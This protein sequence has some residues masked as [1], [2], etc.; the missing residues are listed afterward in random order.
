MKLS[1]LVEYRNYI[2]NLDLKKIKE[3]SSKSTNEILNRINEQYA[4]LDNQV[5]KLDSI[6]QS[7]FANV[8]K[9]NQN[10]SDI[11]S[12]LDKQIL[13]LAD[14]YDQQ[15]RELFEAMRNDSSDW[16]LQ[17]KK[18]LSNQDTDFFVKRSTLYS[19]WT[20]PTL[21]FRPAHTPF[22]SSIVDGFPT[23]YVDRDLDLI[24]PAVNQFP[25]E[26]ANRVRSYTVDEYNT[27]KPLLDKLP[28][29]QYG[30]VSAFYYFDFKPEYIIKRYLEEVFDLLRPGGAFLLTINDCDYPGSAVLAENNYCC[31]ISGL[32]FKATATELGYK[33]ITEHHHTNGIHWYEL[34][35]PGELTTL[36]GGQTMA[37]LIS[38][39]MTDN[40]P[41]ERISEK[42]VTTML[43]HYI[44][45]LEKLNTK[46]KYVDS[47]NSIVYND[48][49]LL[50]E[51]ANTLKIDLNKALEDNKVSIKLLIRLFRNTLIHHNDIPV[52]ETVDLL[53]IRMKERTS[54][55]LRERQI[56]ND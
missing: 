3:K 44:N 31:Y 34:E 30:L 38:V 23:Y 8:D 14:H 50:I 27:Q 33:I 21:V 55:M 2:A 16:I 15:S 41:D 19:N 25:P 12:A 35:K 11:R 6:Q 40:N 24:N 32:K 47:G 43:E 1:R 26:F 4:D 45:F 28:K 48:Q 9:F 17:R 37:K 22:L 46:Y 5:N 56:N 52:K 36:K 49:K 20:Y 54:K 53:K 51:L 18:N 13:S 42:N 29:G 7:I 10:L 39:Y